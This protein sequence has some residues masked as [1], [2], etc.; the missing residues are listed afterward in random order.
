M[1]EDDHSKE[2]GN[3]IAKNAQILKGVLSWADI[4]HLNPKEKIEN[5]TPAQLEIY[6][7]QDMFSVH[8]RLKRGYPGHKR[9][10]NIKFLTEFRCLLKHPVEFWTMLMLLS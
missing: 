6:G 9:I 8:H 7:F 10:C 3:F 2:C 1:Q 5:F 4:L